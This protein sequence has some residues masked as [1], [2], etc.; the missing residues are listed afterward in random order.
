MQDIFKKYKN[1]KMVL[2]IWMIISSLFL[3]FIINFLFIDS[4]NIWKNLK[5]SLLNSKNIEIKSDIYL[6]KTSKNIPWLNNSFDIEILAWKNINNPETLSLSLVYN[7]ENIIIENILSEDIEVIKMWENKWLD[8]II[9]N[10]KNNK[11][12]SINQK[13]IELKIKKLKEK[14]E[15]INIINANFKD[16]TWEIYLLTTSWLTF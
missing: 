15:N 14:T 11:N 3:A 13:I 4:T 5:T 8:S 6:N 9:I 16:S 12:I 1:H 10:F 7:S 2:N